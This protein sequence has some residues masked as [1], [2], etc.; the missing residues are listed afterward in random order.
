MSDAKDSFLTYKKLST[1]KLINIQWSFYFFAM[2]WD[3][4]NSQFILRTAKMKNFSLQYI[5]KFL[6]SLK[7]Q[8]TK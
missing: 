8:L 5:A 7:L 3:N 4:L 1:K 6:I 2:F